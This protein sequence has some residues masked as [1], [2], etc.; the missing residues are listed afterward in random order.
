[1]K[2]LATLLL[3]LV[4]PVVLAQYYNQTI[5]PIADGIG[6][7]GA[8]IPLM[9]GANTWSALQTFTLGQTVSGAAISLNDNS[10][11]N[12]TINTGTSTGTVTIGQNSATPSSVIIKGPVS[13][14][15][16]TA[17][18]AA[19]WTTVSPVLDA[20]AI[21]LNDT[22]AS[23]T[24]PTEAAHSIQAAAFTST[25]GASTTITTAANLWVNA[26]TCSGGLVCTNLYAVMA[27]GKM[28]A[29][30]LI[31]GAGGADIS[32]GVVSLNASTNNAVNIGT[33]TNNA[34]V[35]VGG[36][37]GTVTLNATTLTLTG[38]TLITSASPFTDSNAAFKLT[39]ISTGTNQDTLCLK[40][41]G[42][43]LIQAAACTISSIRFKDAVRPFQGDALSTIGALEVAT[44]R[45]KLAEQPNK[46]KNAY[47]AQIGLI[48]E[49]VAKL[50]PRCAIYEDDLHTPKSYRQ[51][52]VIALLVAGERE[53][54]EQN[55]Q[56]KARLA[57]LEAR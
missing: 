23:G 39:G 40:S 27:N 16:G 47:T 8:A 50:E 37:S 36:G 10:N 34:L 4:S 11:F 57:R 1:M 42:T 28:R 45:M 33:G 14:Q 2:K 52:C 48:A 5:I 41:D 21:T 17:Y 55:R 15:A 35:S 38:S 6:T 20:A 25:G 31:S 12:T 18:S 9:N 26:P 56:L 3:L 43:L 30:G 46:D 53:L 13:F 51:E 49:N 24:I 44:Y 7:S 29:T 22:T 54:M 19:S 32:N